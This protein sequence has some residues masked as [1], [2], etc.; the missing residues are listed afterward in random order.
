VPAKAS[1][2]GMKER[3]RLWS[4]IGKKILTGLTGIAL[5]S[6]IIVHLL[7]NLTLLAGPDLFNAYAHALESKG[8]LIL[9][10]ELGLLTLFLAHA[11][12][13][14]WVFLDNRGARTVENTIVQSKGGPSRQSISSRSMI[15]TGAVLLVFTIIHVVA[16]RFGPTVADGYVTTLHGQPV[17]DLNRLVVETF[18]R[19]PVVAFYTG[20]MIL[21]GLHLRHGFWSAF[22]S[23]GALGP[24][25]R[26]IAYTAGIVFG[27]V[28]AVGFLLLPIWLHLFAPLPGPSNLAGI[29]H[30]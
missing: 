28:I 7:G 12:S 5:M 9:V 11:A 17:R 20:V 4:S 30:P 1:Q 13:A 2:M 21:L 22:Q 25:L 8:A 23:L 14:T 6:F 15:F 10:A 26:P 29:P 18:K 3:S 27:A 24:R 19:L 16:F